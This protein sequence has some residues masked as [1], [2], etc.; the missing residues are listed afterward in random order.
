MEEAR[1]L[2][3]YT[4]LSSAEIADILH[5]STATYFNRFFTRNGGMTPQKFRES[6]VSNP[7]N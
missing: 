2:L 5:F 1:K 7:E 6:G 4:N 3:A